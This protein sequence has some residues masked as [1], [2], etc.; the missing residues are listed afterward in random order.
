MEQSYRAIEL[1]LG[2]RGA[3]DGKVN[4]A[5]VMIGVFRCARILGG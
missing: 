4:R 3:G 2:F 5:G 1:G